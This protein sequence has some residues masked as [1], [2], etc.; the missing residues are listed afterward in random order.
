M[1]QWNESDADVS[2]MSRVAYGAGTTVEQRAEGYYFGGWLNSDTVPG[3]D[4][5]PIATSSLIK[6]DYESNTFTNNT[7]PSD[8]LGRAEGVLVFLPASDNGLLVYFGGVTDPYQNGTTVAVRSPLYHN[9]S[10]QGT[11]NLDNVGRYERM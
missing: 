4:G 8:G 1:N 3:W 6:Y 9:P 10:I 11:A 2:S 5:P 7:G